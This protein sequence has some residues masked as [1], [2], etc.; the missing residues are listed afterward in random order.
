MKISDEML[1][2]IAEQICSKVFSPNSRVE[3]HRTDKRFR[4]TCRLLQR[5]VFL[6]D[7]IKVEKEL[8]VLPK[9]VAVLWQNDTQCIVVYEIKPETIMSYMK[10]E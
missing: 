6:D 5:D 10:W 1:E 2:H 4:L 3:I 8:D 9:N 7:L